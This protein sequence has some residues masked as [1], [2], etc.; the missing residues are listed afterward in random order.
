VAEVDGRRVVCEY[1]VAEFP[2][3]PLGTPMASRCRAYEY[4]HPSRPLEIRMLDA[5]GAAKLVGRC[6]KDTW[7]ED[8]AIAERGIGKGCSLTLKVHEGQLAAFTPSKER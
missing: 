5:Q 3:Q 6:F 1:L 2:V 4:R 8:H 7:Q